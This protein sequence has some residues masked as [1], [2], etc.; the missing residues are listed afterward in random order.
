[1]GVG[2]SVGVGSVD[3]GVGAGFGVGI[4]V[5]IG[6]D[7]AEVVDASEGLVVA[8]EAVPQ[9]SLFAVV[10]DSAGAWAWALALRRA[11]LLDISTKAKLLDQM[12]SASE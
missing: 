8:K 12:L 10:T 7:V 6:L 4:G 9:S 3:V 5:I 2:R 1:M 11:A